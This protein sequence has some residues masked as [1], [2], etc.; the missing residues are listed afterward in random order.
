[1][2]RRG[3]IVASG[4]GSAVLAGG[5][6]A[7]RDGSVSMLEEEVFRGINDMPQALYRVLWPFQQLGVVVV[8]PIVALVAAHLPPF[9]PRRGHPARHAR[10]AAR[11]NG[12]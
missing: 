1:M 9:S 11:W 10:E 8:G 3:D 5:M 2:R 12:S 6:V 7:V 4:S